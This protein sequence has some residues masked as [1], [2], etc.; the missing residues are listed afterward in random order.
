MR[1]RWQRALR[2]IRKG[3]KVLVRSKK[4]SGAD[5]NTSPR[6][7][8]TDH[9]KLKEASR[10]KPLQC[11]ATL[12]SVAYKE[13]CHITESKALYL[14][15]KLGHFLAIA[16]DC[17]H[18]HLADG[19]GLYHA[20]QALPGFHRVAWKPQLAEYWR[21]LSFNE[22]LEYYGLKICHREEEGL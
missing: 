1:T 10:P 16:T 3:G 2:T 18:L 11:K 5:G 4:C 14:Y 7:A 6:L 15:T 20:N 12:I 13:Y 22:F 9:H 17:S 19:P 21:R 8:T